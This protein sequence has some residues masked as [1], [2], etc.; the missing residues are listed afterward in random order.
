[1]TVISSF[2]YGKQIVLQETVKSISK[3]QYCHVTKS[4]SRGDTKNEP[5]LTN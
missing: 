4:L 1:M 3:V 5:I 2:P